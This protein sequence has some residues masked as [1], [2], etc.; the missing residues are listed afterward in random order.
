MMELFRPKPMTTLQVVGVQNLVGRKHEWVR[1]FGYKEGDPNKK[2]YEVALNSKDAVDL[3][4]DANAT[5]TF[6]MIEVPSNTIV[7]ILNT[8]DI[9]VIHMGDPDSRR[10]S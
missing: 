6:P 10:I 9:E 1:V 8:S 7:T 4:E 5:K 2:L 3:I